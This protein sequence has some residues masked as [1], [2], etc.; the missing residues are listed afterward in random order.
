MLRKLQE[1]PIDMS[2]GHM[3]LKGHRRWPVALAAKGAID[4]KAIELERMDQSVCRA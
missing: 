1:N 2:T 3:K 4:M